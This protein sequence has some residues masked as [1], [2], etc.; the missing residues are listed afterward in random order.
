MGARALDAAGL[1]GSLHCW[2][3]L[4]E[5]GLPPG[6][7]TC[8]RELVSSAKKIPN[9]KFPGHEGQTKYAGTGGD[10]RL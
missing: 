2:N 1:K 6:V 4:L 8:T 3:L 10:T 5:P 9:Y 7:R